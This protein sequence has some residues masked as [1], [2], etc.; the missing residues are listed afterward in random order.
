M[1]KLLTILLLLSVQIFINAQIDSTEIVSVADSTSI[2]Q[3]PSDNS[4][5]IKEIKITGTSKYSR[6]QIM[7]YTGLYEGESLEI[8]GMQ[9]NTAVKKLWESKLFADVE[10]FLTQVIGRDAYLR[11]NLKPLPDLGT[12]KFG[13]MSK[14]K[15]EKLIK[16]NKLKVKTKITDDL[17]SKL[18]NSI[19]EQY[20]SKGF[21]DAKVI[22]KEYPNPKDSTQINWDVTLD[23]GPRVKVRSINITGTQE[24]SPSKVR[25]R[26]FKNTKVK[27]FYRF[28]KKSKYVPVKYQE[29][30]NKV[31]ETYQ[32]YGFR[33]AKVVSEEVKRT[34][35]HNYDIDVN[36]SEGKRYYLGDITFTGNSA[37]TTEQLS[38]VI[39][40]RKGEPYDAV[41]IN[42]KI[43][44][45]SD[46]KND[47]I[48][49]AYY[50]NGY[51]W[52]QA[53]P[54]E[55]AVRGD[56]IDLEVR[57]REGEQASWDR[58]TFSGNTRTHDHVIERSLYTK[59]GNLFSKADLQRTM[60]ELA[61]LGYFE[62]TAI[63]PDIIPNPETKTVDVNY[64]LE[65][66]GSSQIQLQGGYGGGR[67][68][69]TVGLT[70]GNFSFRDFL[71]KDAWKPVPLGDGQ[72]I[73][74]QAQAGSYYQNYSISFTEPWITGKRPTSLSVSF[75]TTLLHYNNYYA[76]GNNNLD[77]YGIQVGLSTRLNWPDD[78]FRLAYGI[79]YQ[80]YSFKDYPFN[81]ASDNIDPT[82]GAS[83]TTWNNG[84]SNNFSFYTTL[85]RY[86]AGLDPI[87]PTQGSEVELS[88]KFTP[89]YSL[90]NNRDYKNE[91]ENERFKWLEYYKVKFKAYWYQELIG[92]LVLKAGGEF[93]FLSAYDKNVGAPPFERFYIGGTGLYGN[94]FDG[95]E[96]IPLR[97]YKDS[98]SF[99]NV[100]GEDIT[101]L[102]GGSSY[103]RL[104]LELRYPII[105]GA[106][107]KI[108]G[109]AFI[110]G[111]NAWNN[112]KSFDPFG[113]KRSAGTG[114]RVFMPQFGML[115]FD[116][117]YGFDPAINTGKPNGW[118]THFILGQQF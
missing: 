65:E 60:M 43:T 105:M 100:S 22:I 93:G 92:K 52:A 47:D 14:S 72:S 108:Y 1:K 50:N 18:Q 30:L 117:G 38:R 107:T 17:K 112:N 87:F 39:G 66:K 116:F 103:A 79:N 70:F 82:T 59:P 88:L 63:K 76:T 115:G 9:I 57:I 33:D 23:K 44:G 95:R 26:S 25:S 90:L 83:Y 94:R 84:R 34:N 21:P 36:V 75:Y 101:P 97:G 45:G 98:S 4:F 99:G 46:G 29:D 110:E 41:G 58:V 54:I 73:S 113:L 3:E 85:G 80:L 48:S 2:S 49:S 104:M 12:V 86:S 42:S 71:K 20:T 11:I 62:P 89:P 118:E 6:A 10:I 56:T 69:G 61:Q 53:V 37:F 51:V 13:G 16:E 35:E 32:S 7:R 114:I 55:K 78:Y 91:S 40:Y 64:G 96:I 111:G 15:S 67:F 106:G 109:L 24:L 5:N 19:N 81:I 8:P 68:I 77:I 102:G 27:R 74:L 31:V 28:W